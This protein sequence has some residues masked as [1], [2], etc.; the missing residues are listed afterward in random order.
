[1]NKK[2]IEIEKK[3]I[4]DKVDTL[5]PHTSFKVSSLVYKDT[6]IEQVSNLKK[7]VCILPFE[8]DDDNN[9]DLVYLTKELNL[10]NN[11]TY[12]SLL[13]ENI[14]NTQDESALDTVVRCMNQYMNLNIDLGHEKDLERIYYLGDLEFNQ[15]YN[16][17]IPLYS[18]R[19]NDMVFK[20]DLDYT[21][22][23]RRIIMRRQYTDIINSGSQDIFI[24]SALYLLL[25]YYN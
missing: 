10:F 24:F 25:T 21:I 7:K 17:K 4:T 19:I 2:K 20:K 14:D 6:P 18:V 13:L 5:S 3:L 11:K 16:C 23:D 15:D 1:M 9:I 12:N 8:L 22:D